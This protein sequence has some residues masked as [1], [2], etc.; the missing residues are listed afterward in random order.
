MEENPYDSP[1]TSADDKGEWPK[2]GE[3]MAVILFSAMAILV[4]A[5]VAAL[6]R[7]VDLSAMD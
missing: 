1:K 6:I 4:L 5:G 7:S 2:V 3:A